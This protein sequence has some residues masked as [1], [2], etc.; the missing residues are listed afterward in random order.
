MLSF[1][2]SKHN[3]TKEELEAYDYV[4]MREQDERGRMS[5]AQ[6]KIQTDIAKSLIQ[7]GF[8]VEKIVKHT[9]LTT[10]QVLKLQIE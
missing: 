5:F 7:S 3:W 2:K 1:E 6:R 10:E 9:K 4:L 8:S